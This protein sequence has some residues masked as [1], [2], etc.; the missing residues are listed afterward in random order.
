[1]IFQ[2]NTNITMMT[3]LTI[4]LIIIEHC[5]KRIKNL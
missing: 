2:S 5:I 3:T 4:N 1:M